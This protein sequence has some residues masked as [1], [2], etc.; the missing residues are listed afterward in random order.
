MKRK[1]GITGGI[2]SGKSIVGKILSTMGY[3]VFYSDKEAKLL[4]DNDETIKQSLLELLGEK[5]YQNNQLNKPFIAEKIF[6]DVALKQKVNQ[7]V[8]PVVRAQFEKFTDN[9]ESQL[10]FNEAAILFETGSY[11]NFDHFILVVADNETRIKRVMNSDNLTREQVIARMKNQWNDEQKSKLADFIID[12]NDD[13]LV[14]PQ[15]LAILKT[16][17]NPS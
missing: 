15:V 5:A 14:V 9:Q 7:I 1:I 13:K 6:Q 8:H 11:K 4:M 12:N 3:P 16:L 10:V 17:E 2:G